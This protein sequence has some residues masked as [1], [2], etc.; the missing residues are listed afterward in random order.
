MAARF[1][2][3]GTGD[4]DAATQTHWATSSGGT[5]GATVPGSG[6]TVTFDS[7]SGTGTVTVTVATTVAGVT[8][9]KAGITVLCNAPLNVGSSGT[10]TLSAG[11]LNTNGQNCSWYAFQGSGNGTRALTLGASQITLTSTTQP[12]LL[13]STTNYTFTA[14]TSKL[15]FSG[16]GPALISFGSQ[17]YYDVEVSNVGS[18]SLSIAGGANTYHDL[19]ILGG[20]GRNGSVQTQNVTVSGTLTVTGQ[21]T[22][23]RVLVQSSALGSRRTYTV[24]A[25]SFAN[26][27]FQDITGAGASAPFAGDSLGDADGN[28]GIVFSAPINLYRTGAGGNWSDLASWATDD[29]DVDPDTLVE[30]PRTPRVPL[31]QDTVVIDSRA[32]GTITADMPRTGRGLDLSGFAGTLAPSIATT[33]YGSVTL[34]N[35]PAFTLSGSTALI[36]G[37]RKTGQLLTTNGKTIPQSVRI[38]APGGIYTLQGDLTVAG[39]LTLTNGTLDAND[40]DVT[41]ASL[42]STTGNNFRTLLMRSGTWTLT[43]TG[44]VWNV[45]TNTALTLT[46]GSSVILVADTSSAT[47]TFTGNGRLYHDLVFAGGT[48]SLALGGSTFATMTWPPGAR[49]VLTSDTTTTVTDLAAIG[50]PGNLIT[51]S[52]SIADSPATLRKNGG[53]VIA[54]YLSLTDSTAAGTAQWYAGT[55]SV[56]GGGNTGWQF[57]DPTPGT[58][59]FLPF[60]AGRL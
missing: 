60:F 52:S 14:G 3:G 44:V 19:K 42:S 59:R 50:T 6:D 51:V 45:T 23:N 26:V 8:I 28:A 20:S 40:H 16:N 10:M 5:G 33:I 58:N 15:I 41:I 57:S 4:W 38:E 24:A 37:G 35:D 31:P 32:S 55:H 47:K 18:A 36:L 9:S 12:W 39:S 2:V 1:W 53:T 34:S 25:H 27:D 22:L 29:V 56:D 54:D 49:I 30:T 48:G 43:G 17:A 21:S 11:T 46:R 13:T 7:N